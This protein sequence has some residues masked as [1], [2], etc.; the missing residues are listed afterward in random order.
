M[1][2]EVFIHFFLVVIWEL[3]KNPENSLIF[4]VKGDE[5]KHA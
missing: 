4:Y 3:S 5:Y 1:I 2:F